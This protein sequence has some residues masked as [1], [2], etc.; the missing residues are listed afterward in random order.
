MD[1]TVDQ[2]AA[3]L[4]SGAYVL[5]VREPAEFA[6]CRIPGARLVPLAMLP[7][8]Q[9]QL[10]RD[11][12]IYVVCHIGQRSA[13]AAEFLRRHGFDAVNVEGGT[14]EWTRRGHAVETGDP[15]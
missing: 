10:P 3:A 4:S 7:A 9:H 5:D 11:E 13:M 6:E 2:L 8:H 1:M 15:R 12:T 14:A